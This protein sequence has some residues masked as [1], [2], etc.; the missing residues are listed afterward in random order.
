MNWL[1][2]LTA[3]FVL[4]LVFFGSLW[5]SVQQF[6]RGRSAARLVAG[7][8]ARLLVVGLAFYAIG[9]GG[10]EQ[11]LAALVG[12]WLARW[13]LLAQVQEVAHAR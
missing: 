13:W 10:G 3:G 6:A 12:F 11:L 1:A 5:L 9:R 7:Q 2:M 8:G 4:G